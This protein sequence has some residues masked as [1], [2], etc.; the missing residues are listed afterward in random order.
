MVD[1]PEWLLD[2]GVG[3]DT[4]ISHRAAI[5]D[6]PEEDGRDDDLDSPVVTTPGRPSWIGSA[7]GLTERLRAIPRCKKA[8]ANRRFRAAVALADRP[9]EGIEGGCE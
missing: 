5:P 1:V 7:G 8:E 9:P 2:R 3:I 6:R 4:E